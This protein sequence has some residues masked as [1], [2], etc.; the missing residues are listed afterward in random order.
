MPKPFSKI[1]TY[2]PA[3]AEE[4]V[5]N[6]VRQFEICDVCNKPE[7]PNLKCPNCNWYI[8]EKCVP[9]HGKLKPSH[10]VETIISLD[11]KVKG[12]SNCLK[13]C[14][15]HP[16]QVEDLFCIICLSILCIHCRDYSHGKC[17]KTWGNSVVESVFR[18]R[19]FLQLYIQAQLEL[20]GYT[21]E[22]ELSGIYSKDTRLL[23]IVQIKDIGKAAHKW[24]E[25]IYEELK[26]CVIFLREYE[27]QLNRI[28][29]KINELEMPFKQIQFFQKRIDYA[30]AMGEDLYTQTERLLEM[31][32]D[33]DTAVYLLRNEERYPL[34]FQLRRKFQSEPELLMVG[35][36]S[37]TRR[38]V[39]RKQVLSGSIQDVD[40]VFI[41]LLASR[42]IPRKVNRFCYF[43]NPYVFDDP[44]TFMYD[45]TGQD[46]RNDENLL[47]EDISIFRAFVFTKNNSMS[48]QRCTENS[49]LKLGKD[50]QIHENVE[51]ETEEVHYN[52][53]KAS[54]IILPRNDLIYTCS[55][56]QQTE[57]MPRHE[58]HCIVH[59]ISCGITYHQSFLPDPHFC[60]QSPRGGK[61]GC[62]ALSFYSLPMLLTHFV[63]IIVPPIVFYMLHKTFCV[64]IGNREDC[65]LE[66]MLVCCQATT[67]NTYN[68]LI[69]EAIYGVCIHTPRA[70]SYYSTQSTHHQQMNCAAIKMRKQIIV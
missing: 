50:F 46:D 29:C 18:W 55:L 1:D 11:R 40:G 31:P 48:T 7:N 41:G 64:I 28:T 44:S 54:Y 60:V 24:L 23:R 6:F 56:L 33:S 19:Y 53:T 57:D 36:C 52:E 45:S 38:N 43:R 14:T 27:T 62:I 4:D 21:E 65:G 68:E 70:K 63:N 51:T 17:I 66:T 20:N 12:Q 59:E 13:T 39:V 30:V 61:H 37:T 49:I 42:I 5:A 35:I 32:N 8:C 3:R 69:Y 9:C 25:N 26:E 16:G 58:A 10:V 2:E 67:G 47:F 22:T 15:E 34:L